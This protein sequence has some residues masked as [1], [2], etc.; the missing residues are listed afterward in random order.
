MTLPQVS[1]RDFFR[2][3]QELNKKN[4]SFETLI[5]KSRKGST[6]MKKRSSPVE[7]IRDDPLL[8]S[9]SRGFRGGER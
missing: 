7:G 5:S 1:E 6:S 2:H 8:S 3:S 4:F 9:R